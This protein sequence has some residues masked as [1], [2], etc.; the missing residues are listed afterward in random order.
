VYTLNRSLP[1]AKITGVVSP[2]GVSTGYTLDPTTGNP[3]TITDGNSHK[4]TYAYNTNGLPI[5][6]WDAKVTTPSDSNITMQYAYYPN[7]TDLQTV[8]N[9][10]GAITY[11]YN[12]AHDVTKITDRMP[13]PLTGKTVF[14]YKTTGQLETVTEAQ[15]TANETLTELVYDDDT[16]TLKDIK[17]AGVIIASLTHDEIGRVQ[18]VTYPDGVKITYDY[19]NLNQSKT[20]TYPDGKTEKITNSQLCPNLV[21]STTDR[22][23][24]TTNYQYDALKR[25]VQRDGPDGTFKYYYDN[26]SNLKKFTD[27]NNKDTQFDYDLDNRL[28]TKTYADGKA[29]S[30]TYD[31]AG[32][33]KTFTN[34]R[35]TTN[36]PNFITYGYDE[37]NN[38]MT[39]V[40]SDGTPNVTF[41][42]DNYNRVITRTDGISTFKYFYDA[43]SRLTDVAYPWDNPGNPPP[44]PAVKTI[45][46]DYNALNRMTGMTALGSAAIGYTYDTVGRLWK[47]QRGTDAPYVYTY[48]TGTTEKPLYGSPLVTQLKRPNNS[49]TQYEY[50]DPLKKLTAIINRKSNDDIINSYAYTYSDPA[51]PDLRNSETITN[52]TVID[53]FVAGKTTFN[54]GSNLVNQLQSST[55][56]ASRTI[57]YLYDDDGNMKQAYTPVT[58]ETPTS[59]QMTLGYDAENRLTSAQYTGAGS[60]VY[61]TTYD[62]AGDGLVAVMKKFVTDMNNPVSTTR[63]VRAGFLPVQERN[64]SNTVTREYLWGLNYGGGIGGLLNLK[65]DSVDYNYLYDGKGNVTTVLN[66]NTQI[67]AATYAYD[68]F[69]VRM[70]ITAT[71]D[72]PYQFSTKMYDAQ[73][74]LSDHGYRF[75]NSIV[76]KW[77]TR[78]P[79]GEYGDT[80]LYRAVGNNSVN[81]IDPLG[82]AQCYLIFNNRQGRLI[83]MPDNPENKPVDIPVAS[84]NNGNNSGCKNNLS[85][86]NQTDRGP[87]SPGD[88]VWTN[89]YTGKPNG[90]VLE[91]APGNNTLRD[92]IRSHSC[93]NA[94]GPSLGPDFC[95]KGCVTGSVADI[96][97]LNRL[98]DAEP[99]SRLY[100]PR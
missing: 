44:D 78:D 100:V 70:K 6:F 24:R 30:Y 56:P 2:A 1:N 21:D 96:Q 18:T 34:A 94:F 50:N 41:G 48:D 85:C 71:I 39:I 75:Y 40:Y 88:W 76:A 26:N 12:S 17:K 68:P 43:N 31:P 86:S 60:I 65:Q 66:A 98:L 9:G 62:Y 23:G 28:K 14:T 53:N 20:I 84:G 55:N 74:G 89:G 5:K 52:G 3:A 49:Y 47:V 32:L 46:Y 8:T 83:C 11:E 35:N 42:Y 72:Q 64:A 54:Y 45:H 4:T 25:L 95:S 16:K 77:L 73:T 87:I 58:T 91:P 69:G 37:N 67:P 99:G 92:E 59:Y 93:A 51:H 61:R 81:S 13:L 79:L 29:V 22:A 57:N 82:L 19:D 80:N 15:G 10:L 97:K 38:L 27:A 90:R 7:N 36:A 33:L 63:Y